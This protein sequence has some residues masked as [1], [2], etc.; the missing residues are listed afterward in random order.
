MIRWQVHNRALWRLRE[1]C[2]LSYRRTR[3]EAP[4]GH[5][6]WPEPSGGER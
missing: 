4:A 5:Y 3:W 1:R 6:L 2:I